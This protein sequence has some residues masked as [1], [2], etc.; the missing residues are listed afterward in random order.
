MDDNYYLSDDELELGHVF[1]GRREE[2]QVEIKKRVR[3]QVIP[4]HLATPIYS[5]DIDYI[6]SQVG[7]KE[8]RCRRHHKLISG[9]TGKKVSSIYDKFK[10]P[11][12]ALQDWIKQIPYPQGGDFL[13]CKGVLE[14]FCLQKAAFMEPYLEGGVLTRGELSS[15]NAEFLSKISVGLDKLR[16]DYNNMKRVEILKDKICYIE[17]EEGELM[18][19]RNMRVERDIGWLETG[20]ERILFPT[21]LLLCSADKLQSIFGL[22]LYWL[23]C[24]AEKKYEGSSI[25][26]T[27]ESLLATLTRVRNSTGQE[28]FDFIGC[29]ESLVV[30]HVVSLDDDIGCTS[31]KETQYE[32]MVGVLEKHLLKRDII[33]EILPKS[34][35]QS[36]V[37]MYLELTGMAKILGYPTLVASKL[38][39]QI[40]EHGTDPKSHIDQDLIDEVLAVVKREFCINYYNK[41]SV[42][43]NISE[44]PEDF[45]FIQSNVP[46]PKRFMKQY[47]LWGTIKFAKTLDFNYCVDESEL[48]KDSAAAV[49]LS[50][51]PEMYDPC[52]F[53]YLYNK[54]APPRVMSSKR[55]YKRVIDAYLDSTPDKVKQLIDERDAGVFNNDDHI[56]VECGKECEQKT[57]S[58]RAFTKQ[59][60]DQ[61]LIQTCMEL[62]VSENIF[63][64]VPQQS[65]GDGEIRNVRRIL[66]QVKAL[67]GK[68]EFMCIDFKKWCLNWRHVSVYGIGEIYDSLFGLNR[69]FRDAHLHFVGCGVFNNNRLCPPDYDRHLNPV[70]GD[71]FLNN[72]LGGM[73]GMHQKKWTHVCIALIM[74]TLEKVGLKGEVMGQGDNQVILIQYPNDCSNVSDCRSLFINTLDINLRRMG[75]QLKEKETWFSTHLHEYSKQRV[76]KG[77]AVSSGTKKAAKAIPDINDGLFSTPSM[78]STINTIT[79]GVAKASYTPDSAFI[80]NQFL[81]ANL[82]IRKR[83]VFDPQGRTTSKERMNHTRACL[84]TPADFGGLPLSC[85]YSHAVRG[86]SDKIT[87]WLHILLTAR[88]YDSDMYRIMLRCWQMCP[89][90]GI[91]S[92]LDRRRLYED[93]HCLRIKSLPS[94]ETQIREIS[95]KYLKS[96]RVTN[97]AIR[98]LYE[99]GNSMGNDDLIKQIDQMRPVFAQLGHELL[100]NSNVGILRALQQKLTGSKTIENITRYEMGISLIE[101][102]VEKNNEL[103]LALRRK[104]SDCSSYTYQLM[105][106]EP[107]QCPTALAEKLRSLSWEIDLV[108]ATQPLFG[109]QV[110]VRDLDDTDPNNRLGVLVRL[111]T[112]LVD[113]P[114]RCFKMYGPL[115][116]FIGS[117]TREKIKHSNLD[118]IDKTSYTK[119]LLRLGVIRSWMTQMGAYG[120]ADL[121]AQLME[122]KRPM[123]P[124]LPEGINDLSDLCSSVTS[125]NIFHRFKSTVDHDT[126]IVNC[127]PSI[128]G[129]F[130]HSSNLLHQMTAG[131][132]DFS[133]FYQLL[134]VSNVVGLAQVGLMRRNHRSAYLMEF[135]C[136]NCTTE[137]TNVVLEAPRLML[138]RTSIPPVKASLVVGSVN[139]PDIR[140]VMSFEIGR[141]LAR[142]VDAN[143][144]RFHTHES[145]NLQIDPKRDI[146]SLNDLR[147][148]DMRMILV[149][150]LTHSKRGRTIFRDGIS[151]F[152]CYSEDR[153]FSFFAEK[154]L[155]SGMRGELFSL[156][157]VDVGEHSGVTTAVKLSGYIASNSARFLRGLGA[158]LIEMCLKFE[159]RGAD[160]ISE[161]NVISFCADILYRTKTI[162]GQ[163]VESIKR[164]LFQYKNNG[165]AKR[166]LGITSAKVPVEPEEVI[167]LWRSSDRSSKVVY[168]SRVKLH[169][170][171]ISA[172]Y[173]LE[174]VLAYHHE[175]KMEKDK[176]STEIRL[177]MKF[178]ALC[179]IARPLGFISSAGNK[180]LEALLALNVLGGLATYANSHPGMYI[181]CTAEGSG[182]TL[183]L[184]M[185]VFPTAKGCYN[186]WMTP[187]VSCRDVATDNIP[188]AIYDAGVDPSRLCDLELLASGE[189]NILT[190]RFGEKLRASFRGRRILIFTMDAESPDH[191]NNTE[192][193]SI[194]DDVLCADPLIVI[195]KLFYL[196]QFEGL[197][198]EHMVRHNDYGWVLFKPISSNPTGPEVYLVIKRRSIASDSFLNLQKNWLNTRSYIGREME[199]PYRSIE[200][201]LEVAMKVGRSLSSISVTGSLSLTHKYKRGFPEIGHSL[202]CKKF[203]EILCDEMDLIHNYQG[204][205]ST[206]YTTIRN[207]GTNGVLSKIAKEIIFLAIFHDLGPNPATVVAE[208]LTVNVNDDIGVLRSG[209][210]P[211]V[212]R[213]AR[214][215]P[216]FF[217]DWPE[218]RMFLRELPSSR[219]CS[220]D[221]PMAYL[222]TW[223]TSI[224]GR[225]FNQLVESRTIRYDP[226][227][228]MRGY[229]REGQYYVPN[230]LRFALWERQEGSG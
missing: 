198:D 169:I 158:D 116:P 184:L 218:A 1:L 96:E 114:S 160:K 119:A 4:G 97:V 207:K 148:L 149:V 164:Q 18:S 14:N 82:L 130:E 226:M 215:H 26:E 42:Y 71:N 35:S 80:L 75:H 192:F 161:R 125:G 193:L 60:P 106:V 73:E 134:Y 59:T 53:K 104:M 131:G 183:S 112:E 121:A 77:V 181:Y 45:R 40:R 171:N 27:G 124:D 136:G 175:R 99:P 69:L 205:G 115:K 191:G 23:S 229:Q 195:F 142:N 138:P 174:E 225:L 120:M 68:S 28:F 187:A 70:P 159:L 6:I 90:R 55:V 186:T 78:F 202:F 15:H 47:E 94:A 24:D 54:S 165:A 168:P 108:G 143:Y 8:R 216:D 145:P 157:N 163:K 127:L 110:V 113:H 156:F 38:L 200:H 230:K 146:L 155:E 21:S 11:I 221:Y 102:I 141:K 227:R 220:C 46:C 209:K 67:V 152:G 41:H 197:I 88:N 133:I 185:S 223:G 151:I 52:A 57:N 84:L 93:V 144:L 22:K 49:P 100:R 61:R 65:M 89:S 219:D 132:R 204:E 81:S 13:I 122:E 63:P 137:I 111:S 43:P 2:D 86:H 222:P 123:I 44:C 176:A 76:Y 31:L 10:D 194:I 66:D 139:I 74:L 87:V 178:K 37:L 83:L 105:L 210:L 51:W 62:N 98:R 150:M 135:R 201:Y 177:S 170:L 95:L 12:Q 173:P 212:T 101:L 34:S 214:M 25:L 91:I 36:E 228:F 217:S 162:N 211:Y 188:P 48:T 58:G 166:I 179:Y 167:T 208:L 56:A 17:L 118:L 129:H 50:R 79:E 147:Q 189:T 213:T 92:S 7:A 107:F 9:L 20:D 182:G 32:E 103:Q 199:I 172:R 39:D 128:T 196:Y 85:Y 206:V 29:W 30:G 203:L 64:Y 109:H 190:P 154:I 72:F 19:Y 153:S 5:T 117:T 126:A 140:L 224:S 33:V 3:T 180:F 16:G